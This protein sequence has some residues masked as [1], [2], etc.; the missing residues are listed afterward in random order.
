L[1]STSRI[2]PNLAVSNQKPSDRNPVPAC[3]DRP[4]VDTI[5]AQFAAPA[6]GLRSLRDNSRRQQMDEDADVERA[7]DLERRRWAEIDEALSEGTAA[8]SEEQRQ[9]RAALVEYFSILQE[10][11]TE[12]RAIA[13]RAAAQPATGNA[14]GLTGDRRPKL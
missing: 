13:E 1:I 2:A 10:W 11:A 7:I 12:E 5:T 9:I 14:S 6:D 4:L 3:P 8:L